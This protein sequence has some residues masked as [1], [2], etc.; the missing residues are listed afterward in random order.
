MVN[1]DFRELHQQVIDKRPGLEVLIGSIIPP[2][3]L[4]RG[5]RPPPPA[6]E[7]LQTLFQRRPHIDLT[8]FFFS[9]ANEAEETDDKRINDHNRFK[10]GIQEVIDRIIP[11]LS[12]SISSRNSMRNFQMKI[13]QLF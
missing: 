1:R 8:E 13:S 6:I 4:K 12:S 11:Q 5:R 7:R 2:Q 3:L 9:V 10:Q